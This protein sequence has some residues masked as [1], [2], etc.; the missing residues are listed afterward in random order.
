MALLAS[1]ILLAVTPRFVPA[2][3]NVGGS[4]AG[5]WDARRFALT[6][7]SLFLF[8]RDELNKV[9]SSKTHIFPFFDS[10]SVYKLRG[11]ANH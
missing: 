3:T 4:I 2:G 7:N 8:H 5:Q 6:H 1:C 9:V 10:V 11:K